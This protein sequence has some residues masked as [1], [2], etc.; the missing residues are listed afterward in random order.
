M[1]LSSIYGKDILLSATAEHIGKV[2]GIVLDSGTY[3]PGYIWTD[4]DMFIPY[5]QITRG[6]DIL[7]S[8]H[9]GGRTYSGSGQIFAVGAEIYT[10]KGKFIGKLDD[11]A[12]Q[13][14]RKSLLTEKGKISLKRV[15]RASG[16]YVILAPYQNR[17]LSLNGAE[18][19][20]G[21]AETEIVE[22]ADT[23]VYDGYPAAEAA[24]D[25]TGV[26]AAPA[27]SIMATIGDYGY[28][29]G[30]RTTKEVSDIGRS[31]VVMAGTLITERLIQNAKKAGKLAEIASK[32]SE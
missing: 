32:S 1:L 9:I 25:T 11:V 30:K 5:R 23:A 27:D 19:P 14:K 15:Y 18:K 21:T 28:L 31:F 13:S 22:A 16:A 24:A 3:E 4:G 10:A 20:Y 29:I 2:K 12:L 8:E 17:G 6:K 7:F 26:V